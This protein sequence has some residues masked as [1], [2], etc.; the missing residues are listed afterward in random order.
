LGWYL[1]LSFDILFKNIQYMGGV[2]NEIINKLIKA[3]SNGIG[4]TI[5]D[6]AIL[7]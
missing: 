7:F 2:V 1:F 5:Y 6:N 4:L 3:Q